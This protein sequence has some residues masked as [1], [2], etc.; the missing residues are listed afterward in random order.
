[1][2]VKLLVLVA[3]C[4]VAVMGVVPG[5]GVEAQ[6]APGSPSVER[7]ESGVVGASVA[8]PAAWHVER[9]PYTYGGTYGY[10]LWHPDTDRPHDHGGTPALRVALAYDLE[11]GEIRREVGDR[12]SEL[13]D[14]P[15]QRRTV[16]V[17]EKG[18]KGTAVGPI[19]GSTPYTEVFVPV[20]G[21]VY[22]IDV[23]AEEPGE[24]GLDAGDRELLSKLRFSPPSRSVGSL[25][26]P[27]ANAPEVLYKG[28]DPDLVRREEAARKA[29]EE[30][31]TTEA[32][33]SR[34]A[35][36]VYE[37]QRIAEGCWRANTGFFFQ[38]QH[39]KYANQRWG[40][41]WTGWTIIGRPNFW[42]QYTHGNLD[43]GRCISDYYTNDKFAIDY[44]LAQGDVVF[45]PF[46]SGTVTFAGRNSSHANYG[47]FVTIRAD[48]G[49][50]VNMSAHLSSLASGIRRGAKV[51][52]KTI[53]GFAG[54]T[55]DPSIPVGETH[56]HQ[57]YYR[58]PR[59]LDDGSPYGG[60]GLQV[61]YHR[62]YGT[63]ASKAG[64]TVSSHVYKFGGVSPNYKATCH[65]RNTCGEGYRISN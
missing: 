25:D 61:I 5:A 23:Y 43:Y 46:K 44:P 53:I 33:S 12:L 4:L 57:A 6:Q 28:G 24:E 3:L 31:A 14:L 39:G 22:R 1:M 20:N 19:P 51:T 54:A 15:A 52:D 9:E 16:S 49:K 47:I 64:Y 42:G 59:Y 58:Y 18:Y 8:H 32:T 17:G 35:V 50:Y 55:G 11:P 63:A 7:T 41:K 48:D 10:T 65:E 45:S 21:R 62:Y 30:E 29:T 60:A 26:L 37:E 34:A 36:P 27:N 38:T 40:S 56:L 13:S 2:R